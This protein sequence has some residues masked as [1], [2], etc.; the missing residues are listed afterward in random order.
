MD[1]DPLCVIVIGMAGSGKSTFMQVRKNS[2]SFIIFPKKA[3]VQ[4]NSRQ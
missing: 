2:E 1:S 3:I 4:P